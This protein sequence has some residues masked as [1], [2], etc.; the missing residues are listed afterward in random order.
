MDE[1][2]KF[3]NIVTDQ[4]LS[5]KQKVLQA[6]ELGLDLYGLGIGLVSGIENGIYTVLEAKSPGNMIEPGTNF[7]LGETYCSHTVEAGN[8]LGF[9][10]V[11]ESTI[12]MHP[13]YSHFNLESYIGAPIYK[14]NCIV[15]TVNFSAAA[16]R[17]PFT[18]DDY[19]FILQL[20]SWLGE[21][22]DSDKG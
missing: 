12:A 18:Q 11:G 21:S 19:A 6:L 10:H 4:S 20:A 17:D 7:P 1:L 16:P 3:Q 2:E 9:H 15:G 13:C 22:L 8:A 5:H 14:E